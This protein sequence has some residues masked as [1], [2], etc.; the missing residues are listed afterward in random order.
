MGQIALHLFSHYCL[1][2]HQYSEK[3]WRQVFSCPHSNHIFSSTLVTCKWLF[4][5]PE[6][7]VGEGDFQAFLLGS[8][9]EF[10]IVVAI[11]QLQAWHHCFRVPSYPNS[12]HWLHWTHFSFYFIFWISLSAS[13]TNLSFLPQNKP[14]NVKRETSLPV[15]SSS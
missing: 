13:M 3:L 9:T 1:C 5:T 12:F 14:I 11:V 2:F 8:A 15:L 6:K 7:E 10:H 4:N